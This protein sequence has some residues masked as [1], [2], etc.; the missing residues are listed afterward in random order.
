MADFKIHE[1]TLPI[2]VKQMNFATGTW[3]YASNSGIPYVAKN[4]ADETSVVTI[5]IM[6]PALRG[7]IGVKLKSI[8]VP[9]RITTADLDAVI[10]GT[11]YRTNSYLA[12]A[13]GGVD[14]TATSIAITEAGTSV[15]AA[16][17]DR[18]YVATIPT[19]DWDFTSTRTKQSYQLNLSL[20]AGAASII[21]VYDAAAIYESAA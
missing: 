12:V 13:A 7:E 16:A 6:L 5:P 8:E 2:S 3:T 20:N 10:A 18:L 19:P 21:R 15:T 11:L 1:M 17:T 14:I 9:L 4:A